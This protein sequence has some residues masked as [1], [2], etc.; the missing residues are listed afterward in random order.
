MNRLQNL[1]PLHALLAFESAARLGSFT[2]AAQELRVTPSAVSH[3]IRQLEAKLGEPLF[4]RLPGRVRPTARGEHFLVQ[5]QMAFDT[6][7]KLLPTPGGT[8]RRRLRLGVP[9]TFGRN[10]LIPALPDFY[11]QHPDL[12]IELVVVSPLDSRTGPHDLDIRFG[13]GPFD[14]RAAER[15]FE[16]R[17]AAY[18]APSFVA[19]HSL[20]VPADL[21]RVARLRTPLL[22]WKPW[23]QA[24]HLTLRETERGP[25]H[26]DLGLMM[27]A[28][29]SGQGV[30]LCPQRIAAGWV[31]TGQVEALFDLSVAAPETYH[32]LVDEHTR[33]WPETEQFCTWLRRMLAGAR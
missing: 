9:P 28:A 10:L 8:P 25:P 2:L 7:E 17:L 24:A 31:R 6:L 4:E 30:A 13:R 33:Q 23:L 3:R 20:R 1:P 29:A 32:L 19:A 11:R 21:A 27:E 22:D 15:L 18:A 26:S 5:V 12:D 14:G 16:D